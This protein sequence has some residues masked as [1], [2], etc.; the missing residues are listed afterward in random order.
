MRDS[1]GTAGARPG[2]LDEPAQ[3][4]DALHLGPSSLVPRLAADDTLDNT[5][6]GGS[7]GSRVA[8]AKG[9][10]GGAE[11]ETGGVGAGEG[12]GGG[13]GCVVRCADCAQDEGTVRQASGAPERS[14]LPVGEEE[15]EAK[16]EERAPEI[17]LLQMVGVEIWT[18]FSTAPSS[19]AVCSC[20]RVTL[21]V[22]QQLHVHA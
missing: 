3:V 15:E 16:E 21:S 10:G 11:E 17:F 19:L 4:V 13:G 18:L 2:V 20:A 14:L 5:A 7:L 6:L 8:G 9:A 22:R 1:D 12:V